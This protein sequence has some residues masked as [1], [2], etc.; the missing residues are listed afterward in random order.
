MTKFKTDGADAVV[1]KARRQ[2]RWKQ[3]LVALL[4]TSSSVV[5]MGQKAMDLDGMYEVAQHYGMDESQLEAEWQQHIAEAVLIS[6]GWHHVSRLKPGAF[7]DRS[8]QF[9]HE[10]V[11]A[12]LLDKDVVPRDKV[13]FY[14]CNDGTYIQVISKDTFEKFVG[15]YALN[16][17]AILKQ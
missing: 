15:R 10:T 7:I 12:S 14:P 4:F 13:V 17:K 5:L 1:G 6:H 11:I 16:A 9:Q 8:V 2:L 3:G